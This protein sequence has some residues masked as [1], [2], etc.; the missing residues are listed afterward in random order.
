MYALP[1]Q[2]T[3]AALLALADA[4]HAA[5]SPYPIRAL[6]HDQLHVTIEMI[7]DATADAIGESERGVLVEALREK[8]AAAEPVHTEI[9]H[10]YSN[11]AGV[12]FDVWPDQDLLNVRA[13]VHAAVREVRG[14][15]AVLHDCGRP[16]MALGCARL[17]I[18][19]AG[20]SNSLRAR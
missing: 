15:G 7:T 6:G 8:L 11:R 5:M 18:D 1:D 12:L 14:D 16:H 17:V 19:R 9:G 4:C 13:L 10:P 20:L 3:D 2:D